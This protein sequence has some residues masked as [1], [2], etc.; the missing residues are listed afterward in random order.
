[1]FSYSHALPAWESK[2]KALLTLDTYLLY[3]PPCLQALPRNAAA[4]G[5]A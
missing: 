5:A 2:S 4:S 1:M 3:I